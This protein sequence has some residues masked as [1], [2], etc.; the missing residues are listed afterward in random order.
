MTQLLHGEGGGKTIGLLD[1]FTDV[2][3]TL[4]SAHDPNIILPGKSYSSLL[5]G[6]IQNNRYSQQAAQSLTLDRI[7]FG[8]QQC[9]FETKAYLPNLTNTCSLRLN[10]SGGGSPDG[11]YMNV[12]R[13]SDE[14]DNMLEI[15][16]EAGALIRYPLVEGENGWS[17]E[18]PIRVRYCV[19]LL[20]GTGRVEVRPH[21]QP[22]RAVQIDNPISDGDFFTISLTAA[23][24]QPQTQQLGYLKVFI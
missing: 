4:I 6:E 17:W 5:A 13:P 9:G 2:D 8:M 12:A 20:S 7:N 11:M 22:M 19:D 18:L 24:G 15:T 1:T 21:G 14:E 23:A 10:S 16:N 3:G